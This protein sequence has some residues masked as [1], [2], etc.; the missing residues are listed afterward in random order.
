[1]QVLNEVASVAMRKLGV[2]IGAIREILAVVRSVCTVNALDAETHDLALVLI[3]RYKFALF[4]GLI[5]AAALVAGCRF[6]YT[7]DMQQDQMVDGL[8]IHNPFRR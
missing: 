4:D 7:E 3:D 8:R 2:Q 1:M 6:L 5:V